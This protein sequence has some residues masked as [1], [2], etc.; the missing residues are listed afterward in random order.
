VVRIGAR[1]IADRIGH[2]KVGESPFKVTSNRKRASMKV[3]YV[4]HL[5]RP[6]LGCER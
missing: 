4:S 1:A 2:H 6:D 3:K 5:R